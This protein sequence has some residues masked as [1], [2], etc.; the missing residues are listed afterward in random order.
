MRRAHA[1][2]RLRV[3]AAYGLEE[4][5]PASRTLRLG[6]GSCSQRLAVLEALAR[7]AGIASRSRGLLV[8]GSFWAARFPAL[9]PVLPELVLLAWPEFRAGPA[10]DPWQDAAD[11]FP[12]DGDAEP[13]GNDGPETLFEAIGRGAA[14][15]RARPGCAR[16]GLAGAVRRDLGLFGSRDELF[17]RFGGNLPGPVRGL[18]G[19]VLTA[20]A[21]GS[22]SGSA[23]SSGPAR[24]AQG[25]EIG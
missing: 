17:D 12:A 9:R 16:T 3:R 7:A 25:G 2:V 8:D 20:F 21:R 13:F 15:W 5:R 19:P 14:E 22:S 18:A 10:A 24:H 4:R 1:E 23:P 11:L 6:R